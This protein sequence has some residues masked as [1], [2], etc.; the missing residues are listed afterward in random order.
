MTA[1]E[2]PVP[3]KNTTRTV[4]PKTE[5]ES[6]VTK[7]LSSTPYKCLSLKQLGGGIGNFTYRGF[8]HSQLSDNQKSVIVKHGR[9]YDLTRTILMPVARCAAETAS[10]QL[11]HGSSFKHANL[12]IRT[13]GHLY[14]DTQTRTQ[15]IEDIPDCETLRDY[16]LS[17]AAQAIPS[18]RA[19]TIGQGLGLWLSE[20]HAL[21]WSQIDEKVKMALDDNEAGI[22][23]G[24][25]MAFDLA[26]DAFSD[27]PLA[28]ECVVQIFGPDNPR[29]RGMIHGDFTTRNILIQSSPR[30]ATE[31]HIN[32][33]VIDWEFSRHGCLASDLASMIGFLYI[34][35]KFEDTPS[36]ELVL[37]D[38]IL[39]YVRGHGPLSEELVF[40]TAGLMGILL[41][42]WNRL[43]LIEGEK[44]E[45]RARDIN[46]CT[47]EFIV[48]GSQKDLEWLSNS[49]LSELLRD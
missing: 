22:K 48:M 34:Q 26:I 49:F 19:S 36:A 27:D 11:M 15:V 46:V 33:A 6:E 43:K 3:A 2:E 8:L 21:D 31:D 14:L 17:N 16:L 9:R 4:D 13:P 24:M 7:C 40:R 12:S 10:L 23:E 45:A 1:I 5:I 47:R 42:V 38:F 18:T 29:N 44:T 28:R 41:L 37:R 35:W 25:K 30:G 32:L 20:L 39:G